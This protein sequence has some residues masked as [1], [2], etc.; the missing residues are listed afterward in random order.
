M[1]RHYLYR[2]LVVTAVLL[3]VPS[4]SYGYI[5]PGSGSLFLQAMVG[6]LLAGAATLRFYWRRIRTWIKDRH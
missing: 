5:D 4:K 6:G 3:S 1:P 2:V